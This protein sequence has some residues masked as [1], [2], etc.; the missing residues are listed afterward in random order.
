[1]LPIS[2]S[3]YKVVLMILGISLVL[4]I[5]VRV[6]YNIRV[7]SE[8]HNHAPVVF[9]PQQQIETT[10]GQIQVA[11]DAGYRISGMH[12]ADLAQATVAAQ[13]QKSK[14]TLQTT[15]L[16]LRSTLDRLQSKY[17]GNWMEVYDPQN[18]G[19]KPEQ[20]KPQQSVNL[21]VN[22]VKAYPPKVWTIAIYPDWDKLESGGIKA[23]EFT[24]VAWRFKA[25]GAVGYVG[26]SITYDRGRRGGKLIIGP[27]I[28]GTF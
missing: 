12:A 2:F 8:N 16:Q 6:G 21:G 14:E 11:H 22:V 20:P 7:K 1:M 23:G 27:R 28:V 25:F 5:A 19:V 17:Q 18:P 26:P 13:Q 24:P 4:A 9:T 3:R 10:E 15:G